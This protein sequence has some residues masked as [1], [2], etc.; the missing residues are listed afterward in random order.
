MHLSGEN[1]DCK[2]DW[3]L[4][5]GLEALGNMGKESTFPPLPGHLHKGQLQS[6]SFIHIPSRKGRTERTGEYNEEYLGQMFFGGVRGVNQHPNLNLSI[7]SCTI[8]PGPF[9][10][11]IAVSRRLSVKAQIAR[12]STI[13]L[14]WAIVGRRK[15][16]GEVL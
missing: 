7:L 8:Q 3:P 1:E 15:E 13:T 11:G 14:V 4:C 10:H 16:Q 12:F 5:G 9:V 2:Y 6:S